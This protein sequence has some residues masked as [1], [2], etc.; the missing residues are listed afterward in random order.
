MIGTAK[1]VGLDIDYQ[2]E[3]HE[4]HEGFTLRALRGFQTLGAKLAIGGT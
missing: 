3:G 4:E 1:V 2:H